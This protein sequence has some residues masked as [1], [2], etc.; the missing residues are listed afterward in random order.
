[1][2]WHDFPSPPPVSAAWTA[3]HSR[4]VAGRVVISTWAARYARPPTFPSRFAVP[5]ATG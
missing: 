1:M 2:H 3:S 4:I 5:R